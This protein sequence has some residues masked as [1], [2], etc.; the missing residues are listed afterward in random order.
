MASATSGVSVVTSGTGRNKRKD[1]YKTEVTTLGDGS[2][3]R[4]TFRTDPKGNNAVK[5]Q[6]LQVN[7][8]GKVTKSSISSNA[9]EAEKRA[10]ND[11]NSQLRSSIKQQVNDAGKEVRKNEADAA[12]GRVTDAGKKN[13]EILGGGSG[14]KADKEEE[15]GDNSQPADNLTDLEKATAVD[16]EKTRTSFPKNLIYPIDIGSTKQDVIHF[17]MLE[18][19][20]KGYSATNGLA[21]VGKRKSDRNAIGRVILPIPSGISDNNGVTWNQ[22]SLNPAEALAANTALK[23][24]TKGF[25]AGGEVLTSAAEEVSKNPNEAK[26][27][28]AA[29][30]AEAA[31]GIGQQLLTR[32]TGAVINSNIELLF[33]SPTLRPFTFSFKMSARSKTEA[34]MIIKI[35]RFFKQGMAVQR[36]ASNLFLKS[37]HTFRI[38][39]MHRGKEEHKYI[40]KIKECALQNFTVNYTPEGQYATFYDGVLVSYEIQMQFTELEPI[41]N[42]DYTELDNNKDTEIGY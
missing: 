14:N 4:E 38:K 24:I 17:E 19:K 22:E 33:N 23:T 26:T 36:S 13:Q 2:L 6:E 15:T 34:E 39:Y 9:R 29:A 40:G 18:Y 41:F 10:L 7:S 16:K 28:V 30:F 25:G 1:Y 20:P 12:A 8:E 42:D 31:T 11:P 21:G 32:T 5:V 3:K 37:P 35:I 27:A